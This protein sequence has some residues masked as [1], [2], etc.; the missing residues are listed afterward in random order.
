MD[1]D[2]DDVWMYA[3]RLH[4]TGPRKTMF[5]SVMLLGKG[6]MTSQDDDD[7]DE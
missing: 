2:D 1:D 7:D 5:S 6:R 3:R 4:G